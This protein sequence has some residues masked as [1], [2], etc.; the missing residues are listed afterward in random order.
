MP[1][2]ICILIRIM[3]NHDSLR[4]MPTDDVTLCEIWSER[5]EVMS[6]NF[7]CRF[8]VFLA[9]MKSWL[10]SLCRHSISAISKPQLLIR[11]SR[12]DVL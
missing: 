6:A 4:C 10:P 11:V 12:P 7:N 8:Y 3:T 1:V 2:K 9:A 5:L